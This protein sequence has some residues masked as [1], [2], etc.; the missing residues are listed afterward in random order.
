MYS[1][2]INFD[3]TPTSSELLVSKQNTNDI[4]YVSLLYDLKPI[5]NSRK[6]SNISQLENN[7]YNL[8]LPYYQFCLTKMETLDNNV[9]N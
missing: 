5:F 7:V 3:T 6:D 8:M 9:E 2:K 1:D 4:S